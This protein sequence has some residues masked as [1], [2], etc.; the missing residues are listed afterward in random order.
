VRAGGEK[1]GSIR[2]RWEF[3]NGESR[4]PVGDDR[5]QWPDQQHFGLVR[6]HR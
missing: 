1:G 5:P 3:P 4:E 6:D 2:S